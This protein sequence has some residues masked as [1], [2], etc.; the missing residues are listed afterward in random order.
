MSTSRKKSSSKSERRGGAPSIIVGWR[1][2]V[3]LPDL[4]DFRVKAKIDTG[5]RTS[6]I[7]AWK[8]QPFEKD[9]EPWVRFELHPNQ[10]DNLTRI[11]CEMPVLESRE[12]RSSNGQVQT[13]YVVS[14][15]LRIGPHVWPIELTLTR[16]DEMGFRMLIGRTA[17]RPNAL[18][19]PARSFLC[20][21][22][23]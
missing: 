14:T 18:V 19:D 4:G 13:R 10:D 8:I 20:P 3:G 17:L 6:A 16:R 12:I 9:G 2:W 1:E 15:R 23:L 11:P 22:T 7:H 5:A 21:A